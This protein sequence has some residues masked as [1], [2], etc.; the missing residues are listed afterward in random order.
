[1]K[2]SCLLIPLIFLCYS[3]CSSLSPEPN[4]TN[5]SATYASVIGQT[6]YC[7][8][9]LAGIMGG[10]GM[11]YSYSCIEKWTFYAESIIV[12]VTNHDT[13]MIP[14]DQI[15]YKAFLSEMDWIHKDRDGDYWRTTTS[16][17]KSFARA[18]SGCDW[19]E[20]NSFEVGP[21]HIIV[22]T[23][24]NRPGTIGFGN[25]ENNFYYELTREPLE[26]QYYDGWYPIAACSYS[27]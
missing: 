3:C 13:D 18:Y 7:D 19:V 11:M 5:G 6:W 26:L 25:Q 10:G 22:N 16:M 21:V 27:I 4:P 15:K 24:G 20:I 1:M 8:Q 12:I 23:T 14:T 2:I 9:N 17:W